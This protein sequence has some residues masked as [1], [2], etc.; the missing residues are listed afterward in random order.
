M[1]RHDD[2]QAIGIPGRFAIIANSFDGQHQGV[3]A[4]QV[5]YRFVAQVKNKVKL[6]IFC[7]ESLQGVVQM[8]SRFSVNSPQGVHQAG[9]CSVNSVKLSRREGLLLDNTG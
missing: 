2:D 5:D 1:S 4:C 6:L 8:K 9:R 7:Q 3:T